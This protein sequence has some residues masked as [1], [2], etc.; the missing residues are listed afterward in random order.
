[1]PHNR[2]LFIA[3]LRGVFYVI[4]CVQVDHIDIIVVCGK[5]LCDIGIRFA[6]ARFTDRK[7]GNCHRL[8]PVHWILSDNPHE[9][10]HD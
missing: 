2:Q 6:F 3:N 9:R 10:T 7:H 4:I 1:M 5:S 8:S